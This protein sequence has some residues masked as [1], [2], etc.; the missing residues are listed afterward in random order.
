MVMGGT[1]ASEDVGPYWRYMGGAGAYC[2]FSEDVGPYWRCV[3]GT[4]AYC[5]FSEDMV[6]HWF[7]KFCS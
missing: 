4:G 5:T 2:T 3:G 1:G 7:N 6:Y